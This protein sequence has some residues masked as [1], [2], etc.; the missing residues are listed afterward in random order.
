MHRRSCLRTVSVLSALL[1]ATLAFPAM[2]GG[3]V[4]N[5]PFRVLYGGTTSQ[6]NPFVLKLAKGAKTVDR[7]NVYVDGTCPDGN[8]ISFWATLRFEVDTP[9]AL[10]PGLH[11]VAEDRVRKSGS[12]SASGSGTEGFGTAI[13]AIAHT[14]TGKVRRNG[15]ASGTYRAK[16][17]LRDQATGAE[18][19]TCDTGAVG[20]T[21]R[22]SRGRVYA[23]QT[24]QGL[25]MV[26]ELDKARRT[27][28]QVRFGWLGPCTPSGSFY[29]GDRISDFAITD[30]KFNDSFQQTFD[31]GGGEKVAVDYALDG[32]LGKSKAS[33]SV[34]VKFTRTDAAGAVTRACDSGTVDWSLPST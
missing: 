9:A 28:D 4:K 20:W 2:S 27:V 30:R 3:A 13:G 26:I 8:A 19:Q 31:A 29:I 34:S 15:S 24:S 23:G 16:I 22:S 33:G 14:I 5:R 32:R 11:I 18:I 21:G 12:F 1:A 6:D 17:L 10:A 25:P 7:A